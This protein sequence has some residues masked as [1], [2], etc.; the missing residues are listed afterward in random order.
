MGS[1]IRIAI[2][3]P[4]ST[5]KTLL[6]ENLAKYYKGDYIP[7]F[8][9][10]Y[11]ESLNRQYN[12][13]DVVKIAEHILH[14]WNESID[15]QQTIFFDTEMII[16]KVWF[17]VVFNR[18]PTEMDTWLKTM[19]FDAFLLCRDDLPWISDPVRENG[20]HMRHI[21]LEKY[22]S[23]ITKTGIP[24]TIIEGEGAQRIANASS[25]LSKLT[26]LPDLS[27]TILQDRTLT[28]RLLK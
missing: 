3:G 17:Q 26:L 7:E 10:N 5:G 13:N 23:E 21:L 1:G 25:A 22:K 15:Q 14:T 18:V 9:R 4:E 20:G 27:E 12:Y 8:A 2:I 28:S 19:S 11:V 24:F 6:A 16:T